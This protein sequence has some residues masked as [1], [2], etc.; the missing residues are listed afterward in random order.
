[1]GILAHR[2]IDELDATAALHQ[3]FDSENLSS[4]LMLPS[5]QI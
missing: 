3:F 4:R 1:V 5:H 2:P